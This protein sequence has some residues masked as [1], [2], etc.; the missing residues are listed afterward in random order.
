MSI[1][2]PKNKVLWELLVHGEEKK[3][4]VSPHCNLGKKTKQF[5]LFGEK[6]FAK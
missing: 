2:N 6:I 3:E 5:D 1:I 4:V